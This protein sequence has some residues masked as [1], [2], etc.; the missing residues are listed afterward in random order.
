MWTKQSRAFI[1]CLACVAGVIGGA[2][3][4]RA[5]IDVPSLKRNIAAAEQ[6]LLRETYLPRYCAK[7]ADG[8]HFLHR[9]LLA[10]GNDPIVSLDRFEKWLA[11]RKTPAEANALLTKAKQRRNEQVNACNLNYW[12]AELA[13]AEQPRIKGGTDPRAAFNW[14]RSYGGFVVQVDAGKG[15]LTG[16]F[17]QW[18]F[19]GTAT[20]G[21]TVTCS[22]KLDPGVTLTKRGDARGTMKCEA[23]WG[24]PQNVW[25]CDG[26]AFA[27]H[28]STAFA[29]GWA[30]F[31]SAG[32]GEGAC[33]GTI[34][35]GGK[36]LP[37]HQ[38]GQIYLSSGLGWPLQD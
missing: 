22:G 7:L 37:P 38:F 34:I 18:T 36:T 15:T 23:R 5:Q 9:G 8:N 35:E 14:N 10:K 1:A 2:A 19:T 30:W 27:A 17:E 26:I 11:A 25:V 31:G 24:A 20:N 33:R 21:A 28:N 32:I 12:K 4:V 29:G 3:A 13:K 6:T 16:S